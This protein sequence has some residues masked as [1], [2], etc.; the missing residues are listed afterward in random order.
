MSQQ[1]SLGDMLTGF[2]EKYLHLLKSNRDLEARVLA[3]E[4]EKAEL[5]KKLDDKVAL[6]DI[7]V[8]EVESVST[9]SPFG[10]LRVSP[11]SRI[12]FICS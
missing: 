4:S 10:V 9:K 2:Y 7:H 5:L 6:S 1:I 3:L 8:E 12:V 11:V